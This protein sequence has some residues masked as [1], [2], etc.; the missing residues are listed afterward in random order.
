MWQEIA[1]TLHHQNTRWETKVNRP[2]LVEILKHDYKNVEHLKSVATI[3]QII[4]KSIYIKTL[5]NENKAK[6]SVYQRIW[7]LFGWFEDW[8]CGRKGESFV[9][10]KNASDNWR[11]RLCEYCHN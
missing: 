3:A 2:S 10:F 9:T 11:H 8:W 7:V 5:L 1:W 6:K 4:E